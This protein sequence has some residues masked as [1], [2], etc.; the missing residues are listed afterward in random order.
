MKNNSI[1]SIDTRP[2]YEDCLPLSWETLNLKPT[3]AE[4]LVIQNAN[5]ETLKVI[6]SLDEVLLEND[7]SQDMQAQQL[8]RLDAKVNFLMD[9]V[10][11]LLSSSLTIPTPT[12]MS[13]SADGIQWIDKRAPDISDNIH[14]QLYLKV[15][16][17]KPVILP[18]VVRSVE[19]VEGGYK[20]ISEF[21]SLSSGVEEWIEKL[22]FR[23]HRRAIALSRR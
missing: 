6:Y 22:I 16:Y 13:L 17:P 10:G 3:P 12:K 1:E 8:M 19:K 9:M 23:H 5:E 11:Q 2:I 14:V 15:R 4:L 7:D 20:I 18:V 21:D